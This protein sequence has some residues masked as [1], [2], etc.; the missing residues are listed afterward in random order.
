M[1]RPIAYRG[2]MFTIAYAVER[3]GRSPGREFFDELPGQDQAKVMRLFALLAEQ[4][5]ITNPEK[6]G[7]LGQGFREFKSFQIRMPCRF[8]AGGIVLV[9]HGFFKKSDKTPKAEIDRARRI[10]N[11]DQDRARP[12][13]GRDEGQA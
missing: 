8:V 1:E 2:R 11:E 10:F 6:F 4:G 5:K 13:S 9:T 3:S 7:D 12:A